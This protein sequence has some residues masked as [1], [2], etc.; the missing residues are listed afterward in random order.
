[1]RYYMLRLRTILVVSSSSR[2]GQLL[3]VSIGDSVR[4]CMKTLPRHPIRLGHV[5][6][7]T[8][9]NVL[10]L[11]PVSMA[12]EPPT[13]IK[14]QPPGQKWKAGFEKHSPLYIHIIRLNPAEGIRWHGRE[15]T[16]IPTTFTSRALFPIPLDERGLRVQ[17][18]FNAGHKDYDLG[19]R[20]YGYS[21]GSKQASVTESV[22]FRII[23]FGCRGSVGIQ[24]PQP[25]CAWH[26]L[27][28]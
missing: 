21:Q 23:G 25:C 4:S 18:G 20:C 28:R 26:V 10:Y 6:C 24:H 27:Q 12:N 9:P 11:R 13:V 2:E 17:G 7:S 14:A 15:K 16:A 22:G 19:H 3:I 5:E 1:M 8:L